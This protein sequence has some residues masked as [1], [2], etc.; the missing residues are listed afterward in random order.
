MKGGLPEGVP[1]V[2]LPWNPSGA[3]GLNLVPHSD[4]LFGRPEL[5]C[6]S[7][8]LLDGYFEGVLFRAWRGYFCIVWVQF[9]SRLRECGPGPAPRFE[10]SRDRRF[11]LRAS[12]DITWVSKR[13]P[14][15]ETPVLGIIFKA[16]FLTP[17]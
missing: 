13:D 10:G 4:P 8:G 17:T 1:K 5:W 2:G 9:S 14:K 11:E 16:C 6:H 7:G 15:R 12:R 3:G